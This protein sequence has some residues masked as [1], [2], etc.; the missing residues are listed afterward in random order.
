MFSKTKK[1]AILLAASALL[2]T[3]LGGNLAYADTTATTNPTVSNTTEN[4]DNSS[5]ATATNDNDQENV[6]QNNS[7]TKDNQTAS[8]NNSDTT[9][10]ASTAT[11]QAAYQKIDTAAVR[12]AML[13]EL[14]RLRAQNNLQP[15]T[16]VNTLNSYAQSRTD[17]FLGSGGVDNHAGWNSANMYPYNLTAEE[18][19]AQMPYSMLGTTDPTVIAQKIT[20]EFY[21]EMYDPEPNYGHRK[22]MLNPYVNF[23][24]IGVSIADN[25]M[26][27]FSQEMGNNQETYSKYDAS[28]VY[29]YYLTNDNDYANVSQYDIADAK[30]T[31][32]D[33]QNRDNYKTADLRGGVTTKNQVTHLYDRYGNQRTDLALAPNSEWISDMIAIIDGNFYY[34][35]STNGFVAADDALPWATFL[36]GSTVRTTANAKVYD[37]AGNYTGNT[38]N[39]GTEWIVDRRAVNPL[40]NVKMYRIG[41]NAWIQQNQLQQL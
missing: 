18:N 38:V 6:V 13:S 4:S 24:G 21:S 16:S 5:V 14:N 12:V 34:H 9:S 41:T 40:T 33:Y 36:A 22:N 19:I 8:T 28:D 20:N 3:S 1:T 7:T 29:A 37:N 27:Y 39:N 25:G 35:V 30:K 17:S 23:V 10:T 11:T 31:D 26:I 2:A 32:A 15:L